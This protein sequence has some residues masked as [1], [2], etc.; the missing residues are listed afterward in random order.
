MTGGRAVILG[1][2]GRNFAAGM[3]GGVAYILD[4]DADFERRCN[5]GMVD[6]EELTDD[7]EAFVRQLVGRHVELTGSTRGQQVL[8]DWPACR[9]RFVKVMP[10]DYKRVLAAEARARAES[11]EPEFGEL[12][13]AGS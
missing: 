3:S 6:L 5:P 9:G 4:E 2:A 10:R 7:D 11:R 13:G 12:I 8:G 1:R